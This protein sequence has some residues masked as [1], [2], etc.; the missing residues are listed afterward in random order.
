M[1]GLS[2]DQLITNVIY[3]NTALASQNTV[4]QIFINW[5]L[6]P[7]MVAELIVIEAFAGPDQINVDCYGENGKI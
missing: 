4:Q 7:V 3:Q 2:V 6:N 5:I 1:Q